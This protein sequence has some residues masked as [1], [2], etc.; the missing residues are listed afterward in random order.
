MR[1]FLYCSRKE[2]LTPAEQ[3]CC[4]WMPEHEW[5]IDAVLENLTEY[6]S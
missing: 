3:L 4:S 5:L 6:Q 1:P 2:E